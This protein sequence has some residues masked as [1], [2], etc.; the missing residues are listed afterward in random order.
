MFEGN[1]SFSIR[2]LTRATALAFFVVACSSHGAARPGPRA[3]ASAGQTDPSQGA[4]P[5][6]S[7][8][9]PPG[10]I[11]PVQ[12]KTSLSSD[13][14]KP[15]ERVVGRIPQD[16]PLPGGLRIPRGTKV[17]GEVT[18]V[19]RPAGGGSEIALRFDRLQIHGQAV[20]ILT[21]LRAI[22]GFV[23][24]DDAHL[25][26]MS[27]GEGEVYRW[28][29]TVQIGGDDV[30]GIGGAV[31]RWN[32]PDEVV[33]NETPD[34]L[35]GRVNAREGTPC[36]GA[37]YGNDAPQALWVFSS[38]ACGVYGLPHVAIAHAGRSDP[39]GVI[40]LRS[41]GKKLKVP[42]GTGML[43]RVQKADQG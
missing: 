21:N 8:A 13:K 5:Q 35:L 3:A 40:V 41:P 33:G 17:F 11:L 16:V 4:T 27:S 14:S 18:T 1:R 2:T 32:N 20:P 25:P 38:D 10:T 34:G 42:A 24:I 26:L 22:A 7:F 23:E 31:T 19:S 36:S 39:R 6:A 12:L 28:L 37:L 9:L 15:G 29:P 30:Y 43:L